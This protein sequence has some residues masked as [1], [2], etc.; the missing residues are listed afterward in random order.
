VLKLWKYLLGYFDWNKTAEENQLKRKQLSD[1][2]YRMKLQWM[3]LSA[4]QENRFAGM[5]FSLF[6]SIDSF[7]RFP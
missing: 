7:C 5:H 1:D 3:T 2:Y 4:D 6:D